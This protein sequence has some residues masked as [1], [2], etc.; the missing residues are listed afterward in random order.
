MTLEQVKF[1]PLATYKVP[2]IEY[3]FNLVLGGNISYQLSI[4]GEDDHKL[5]QSRMNAH[6]LMTVTLVENV[7]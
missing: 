5:S 3:C 7:L 1:R 2:Y 6:N 4:N